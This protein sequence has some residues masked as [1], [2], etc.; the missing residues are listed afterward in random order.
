[1][2]SVVKLNGY[3]LPKVN[4]VG[5]K[6]IE[7]HL[8]ELDKKLPTKIIHICGRTVAQQTSHLYVIILIV[9]L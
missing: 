3:L 7:R 5:R 8:L 6:H 2:S 1:M 4:E 9:L